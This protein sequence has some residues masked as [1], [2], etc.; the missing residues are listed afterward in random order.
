MSITPKAI[1]PVAQE[2]QRKAIYTG[3]NSI[4]TEAEAN[5]A[6]EKWASYYSEKGSVFNGLNNFACDICIRFD[7]NDQ[8]RELVRALNRALIFRASVTKNKPV[9]S[10]DAAPAITELADAEEVPSY[11]DPRISTPD[12]QTFQCLLMNIINT[13]EKHNPPANIALKLFLD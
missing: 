13:I 1:S 4:L 11:F 2:A 7:K 10:N 9:I 5:K 3:L 6:L 8:Q 12:F